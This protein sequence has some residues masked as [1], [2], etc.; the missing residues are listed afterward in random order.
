MWSCRAFYSIKLW[1]AHASTVLLYLNYNLSMGASCQNLLNFPN[2]K[3]VLAFLLDQECLALEFVRCSAACH[4]AALHQV[5]V[6]YVLH[7]KYQHG[8][9]K[10][11][12]CNLTTCALNMSLVNPWLH[13]RWTFIH[14]VLGRWANHDHLTNSLKHVINQQTCNQT[15]FGALM[16]V[17]RVAMIA[18]GEGKPLGLRHF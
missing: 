13:S 18:G 11:G 17:N 9:L 4:P 3:S 7:D 6:L 2:Q 5:L 15:V 8:S 10:P 16:F 12:Y 14:W 1:I